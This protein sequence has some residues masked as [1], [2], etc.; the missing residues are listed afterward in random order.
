MRKPHTPDL[1]AIARRAVE[2]AGFEPDFPA[3]VK[4]EVSEL[5]DVSVAPGSDVRDMRPLLWSSIDNRESRD[6]DQVEYAERVAGG[7]RVLVG[8]ADV[9]VYV[10][11]GSAIDRRAA[12]NTV[13]VYTPAEVFPMLPEELS[14]GLTS[15]LEGEDRLAVVME[16]NVTEGG[17]ITS[18][19]VYRA[20]LRN[21]AKM[22]Y[23]TAGAWLEGRGPAPGAFARVEGLEEQ[24]RLQDEIARA[25]HELRRR[26]GALE[27]E[28]N[29]LVPVVENGRIVRLDE[30]RNN[31][32]QD[33]IESLMLAA[34]TSMAELLE[35][36]GV[37][38]LRRVVRAPEMWPQIVETAARLGE[39][40]PDEPDPRALSD[41]MQRR[42]A[43][44]PGSYAELSLSILKML[45][46]GDYMVEAPG[47]EQEGHFGLAVHDYTHSTAPNRRF[48]DLVTQRCL[49]AVTAGAPAPYTREQLEATAAH[50]NEME[51]A[52]RRVERRMRK[53]A[54][55]V[56]LGE[57]VGE[58]FDAIVTGVKPKGTFA[59][60]LRPPA[61]GMVVR[62]SRGLRVGDR[63][64]VKL[65]STDPERGFIDFARA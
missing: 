31:R 19:Q 14:T 20:A 30:R 62:R 7:F 44:D 65:L 33:I 57:H 24:V 5:K 16:L 27:L 22:D 60:L 13:S 8:I 63:I 36:K 26:N 12:A 23:D 46:P 59:R 18:K 51:S 34:N 64:R 52:A 42:R 28:R 45:G 29:E 21:R 4:R 43:A 56:M 10:R 54:A 39:H 38:S 61:D 50:C 11:A 1:H 37:P 3:D 40:L 35:E 2:E 55:A 47:L 6:L 9:D 32:A 15:L 53:V 58:T 48:P 41:F 17:D 49:K 25:L